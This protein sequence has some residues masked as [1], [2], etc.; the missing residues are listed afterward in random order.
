L[1]KAFDTVNYLILTNKREIIGIRTP[2][3]DLMMFYLGYRK[4]R[5]IENTLIEEISRGVPQGTVLGLILFTIFLND[6]HKICGKGKIICHAD[7]F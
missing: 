1:V 2:A 4:Q 5:T 7:E 6:I 3:L